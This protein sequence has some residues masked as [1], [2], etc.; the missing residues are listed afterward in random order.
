M[1]SEDQINVT[2]SFCS[3]PSL[4]RAEV[5]LWSRGKFKAELKAEEPVGVLHEIKQRVNFYLD[6]VV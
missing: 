4:D 5:V 3:I 2:Y 1:R 6:L